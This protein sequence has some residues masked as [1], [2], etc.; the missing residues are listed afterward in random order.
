M[1]AILTDVRWCLIV[2]LICISLIIRDAE[3][4]F[5]CLLAICMSSLEK[6]L[7]ALARTS[8]TMLNRSGKRKKQLWSMHMHISKTIYSSPEDV[9]GKWFQ[10]LLLRR[11]NGSL[12]AQRAGE[13]DR[14]TSPYILSCLFSVVP[15]TCI[16]IKVSNYYLNLYLFQNH[17]Q[18]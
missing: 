10:W 5:M 4:L 18:T 12:E 16:T 14:E 3:H 15:C 17:F 11:R 13:G 8:S 7:I 9:G 6:C 2:V 1:T